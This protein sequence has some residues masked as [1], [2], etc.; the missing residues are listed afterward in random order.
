MHMSVVNTIFFQTLPFAF[1]TITLLVF[2]KR[3]WLFPPLSHL[4]LLFGHT[5][6]LSPLP[7]PLYATLCDVTAS[8]PTSFI[9][10]SIKMASHLCDTEIKDKRKRR[11]RIRI[12]TNLPT[13][14]FSPGPM[15]QQPNWH[16]LEVE[17]KN[18][19]SDSTQSYR[20]KTTFEQE[21]QVIRVCMKI[22]E[23]LP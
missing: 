8:G 5:C 19:I 23:T 20:I 13:Q 2:L 7:L 21:L 22:W 16:F 9:L 17:G 4:T 1:M 11:P 18:K 6:W 15:N 12:E 14:P 3:V 10:T